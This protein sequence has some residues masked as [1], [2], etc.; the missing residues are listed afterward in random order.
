M[1][2]RLLDS[3]SMTPPPDT[4]PDSSDPR[5]ELA[6]RASNEGIWDWWTDR[7]DIYYSRRILEFLECGDRRPPNIF[8]PP[9]T[10]IHPDD[11]ESFAAN[12]RGALSQ[13]GPEIFGVDSRVRTGSGDWLWLRIR[14]AVVRDRKGEAKRIA[15]SMIDISRR[16]KAEAQ[17]DEERHL[18]RDLIDH[19]PLMVYFKD[20]GS[21]FM[22]VNNKM[23]Q[24]NGFE[25]P[26]DMV[27]KH[28]RDIFAAAHWEEAETD[29]KQIMATGAPITGKLEEEVR[30]DGQTTWVLTSKFPWIGKNGNMRGTFGVSSDVTKLVLAEQQTAALARELAERNQAYEEEVHLAR[31]IQQAFARPEVPE[32]SGGG[33]TLNFAS[34]YLPISGLAGDF[35]EIVPLGTDRVGLLVCDVM[36]HG[37]RSALVVAMLRGLLEKERRNATDPSKFLT[38][39]NRGLSAIFERAGITM[40][41]TAYY[42]VIDLGEAEIRCACAGHPCAL[43]IG[44]KNITTLSSEKSQ[45]GPGLGLIPDARFPTMTEPLHCGQRLLLFTDGITEAEDE[46]GQAFMEHRLAEAAVETRELPLED[47]LQHIVRTVLSHAEENRFD[48]DVCLLAAELAPAPVAAEA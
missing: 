39:L 38:G 44:E 46:S 24:W 41:A 31:E 42:A 9:H 18:L 17:I 2:G 4:T 13:G 21:R 6:L 45:R 14:G 33:L 15:G 7:E 19:V 3:T 25:H 22:V 26:K 32:V 8:L 30:E 48:D 10:S 28:D 36:G 16:K 5:L 37:V 34:R 29:E 1:P 47:S 12:L 11:Q 23:A 43:L 35:F 27:G 40:F 20:S